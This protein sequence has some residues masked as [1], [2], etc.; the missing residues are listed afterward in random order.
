MNGE[1]IKLRTMDDYFTKE[2][3]DS[4]SEMAESEMREVL[5]ELRDSKYWVAIMKYIFIRKNTAQNGLFTLDPFKDQTQMARYQGIITGILD[6][7]EGIS[8]I[9]DRIEKAGLKND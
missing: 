4:F 3:I 5:L 2:L 6:L 9:A 1:N 8:V 7:P